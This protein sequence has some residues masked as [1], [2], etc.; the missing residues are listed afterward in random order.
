VRQNL[1]E[2]MLTRRTPEAFASAMKADIAV[3]GK[4]IKEG[5]LRVQ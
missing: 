1:T 3:L 4:L 5:N 2:D